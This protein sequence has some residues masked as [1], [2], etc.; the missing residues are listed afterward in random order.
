MVKNIY[1]RNICLS[2]T[3]IGAS[4][5]FN[6]VDI[7]T[8]SIWGAESIFLEMLILEIFILKLFII[9]IYNIANLTI[10]L[11]L[12]C[13]AWINNLVAGHLN[14]SMGYRNWCNWLNLMRGKKSHV[15]IKV[16]DS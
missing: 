15:I 8:I 3:Y 9:S 11:N 1:T 7:K 5:C 10:R 12:K 14:K 16:I 6:N 13:L 2:N 4:I